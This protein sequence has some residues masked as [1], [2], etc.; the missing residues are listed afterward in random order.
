VK[1]AGGGK[2]GKVSDVS[3][4]RHSGIV[5]GLRDSGL[6]IKSKIDFI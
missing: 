5:S 1:I 3:V 2:V 4:R 6:N